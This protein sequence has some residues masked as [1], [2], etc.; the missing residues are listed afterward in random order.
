[1]DGLKDEI[2]DKQERKKHILENMLY[3]SELNQKNAMT[4]R[5][6]FDNKRE[7]KL[8]LYTGDS[9]KL[10]T[11]KEWNIRKFDIIIGNPPYNTA[12][13]DRG[14]SPLYN[15]F[16]QKY[17]D[18]CDHLSFITPS[19]WFS[20]GKGLDKFR[21]MMLER[22]DVVY[23]KHFKDSK[24][25]FGNDVNVNGGIS[26]FLKSYNHNSPYCKF[27]G[28]DMKL[29]E[30]NVLVESC[31]NELIDKLKKYTSIKSIYYP[32]S[33]YDIRT[34]SK[35]VCDDKKLVKC[36]MSQKKGFEKYIDKKSITKTYAEWKLMTPEA[37][38]T[39]KSGF[40][41]VFIDKNCVYSETYIS[42]G[43]KNKNE[44]ESLLSYMKYKLPNFMLYLRKNSQHISKNTCE[45]IPL[46]PLDREW[47]DRDVYKYF[48]LSEDDIKL[49]ENTKVKYNNESNYN[50]KQ[51]VDNNVLVKNTML[52]EQQQN[53]KCLGITKK[54][55]PC[56][57]SSKYNGYCHFHKV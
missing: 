29:N 5:N 41:N 52:E 24:N 15:E 13:T 56:K 22:T 17:I 42:F 27:N 55:T 39:G 46:P 8:N 7:Y 20:G 25:I 28:S 6:I 21:K 3:M 48:K 38:Y 53:S 34:N 40:A 44:A 4:C 14:S 19:K 32:R 26:Y 49:I 50:K 36:Y 33:Y 45:W 47:N 43:V 37:A 16:I 2:P 23:I 9:L 51:P 12:Q 11:Q 1:M 18:N 30:Y 54:K 57:N 10:D 31:Y 35:K